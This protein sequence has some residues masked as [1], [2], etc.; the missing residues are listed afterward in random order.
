MNKTRFAAEGY[1]DKIRGEKKK[2]P[3]N[4]K[5][6]KKERNRNTKK[7]QKNKQIEKKIEEDLR[8]HEII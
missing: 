5:N 3:L 1:R 8:Q 4:K 2:I 6:N 7:K